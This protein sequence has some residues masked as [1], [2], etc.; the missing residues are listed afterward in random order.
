MDSKSDSLI[1]MALM[2]DN[3]PKVHSNS[4]TCALGSGDVAI[5]FKN[6][7]KEEAV[8]NLSYSSAKTLSQNPQELIGYLEATSRN[9]IMTNHQTNQFLSSKGDQNNDEGNQC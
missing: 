7:S 9:E 2:N 6:G 1:D 5:L 3:V 8:L 4:F